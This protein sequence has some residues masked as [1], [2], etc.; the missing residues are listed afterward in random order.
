MVGEVC[1]V[2]PDCGL[3]GLNL[4]LVPTVGAPALLSVSRQQK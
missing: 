4:L 2:F 1:E 3:C